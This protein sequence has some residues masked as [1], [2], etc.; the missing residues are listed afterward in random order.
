MS[1]SFRVASLPVSFAVRS[2]GCFPPTT[3]CSISASILVRVNVPSVT[4]FCWVGYRIL[5]VPIRWY[6]ILCLPMSICPV[7][8]YLTLTGLVLS[9]G[10][11]T[12]YLLRPVGMTPVFLVRHML[13]PIVGFMV[14]S[15]SRNFVRS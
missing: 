5:P 13:R 2:F 8:M 10:D 7:S 11:S 1:W 9:F 14:T 4:F 3:C 12:R 15:F 6:A